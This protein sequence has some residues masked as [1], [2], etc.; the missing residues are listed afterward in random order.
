MGQNYPTIEKDPHVSGR[1]RLA[2]SLSTQ[3]SEDPRIAQAGTWYRIGGGGGGGPPVSSHSRSV[4]VRWSEVTYSP[5]GRRVWASFEKKL[6]K[7]G[8]R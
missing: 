3:K 5:C 6:S 4:S 1:W 7:D 2:L 8:I